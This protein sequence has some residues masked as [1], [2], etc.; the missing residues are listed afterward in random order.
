MNKKLIA[1]TVCAAAAT[2][3]IFAGP[4]SEK[5]CCPSA[6]A[7]FDAARRPISNPTLFDLALPRTGVHAIYMHH[8][9]PSQLSLANGGGSIPVGGDV[10]AYAIQFEYALNDRLSI[11]A[12]KDGYVDFNP[13]NNLSKSGGFADLAAGVK[14]AFILD[15]VEQLAVSGTL[16][17]ELP[18]GDGE[19][20]QGNGKGGANLSVAALK[21][22]NDWQFAGALGAYIP[23]DNDAEST[24]GFASA[25]VGYNITERL[26]GLAE[27]NWYGVLSEGA[28]NAAFNNQAGGIVPAAVSFEGGDLFNLGA[29]NGSDN[30]NIVTAAV[31][32]RYKLSDNA[33]LGLA[34]ELPL[35][36]EDENLMDSRITLDLVLTF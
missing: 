5:S 1:T 21:L 8:K 2:S 32:V 17:I 24:T 31:G 19:V 28:G 25:H 20:F 35:T 27:V 12:T 15:P 16:T 4:A 9:L 34:Y 36:D 3:S 10:N 11:V 23:F 33:D 18:T 29:A 22:S 30:G 14:Y 7:G 6:P 26:Y 13:D